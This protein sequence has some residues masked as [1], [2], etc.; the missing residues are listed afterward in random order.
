MNAI[1]EYLVS[2]M[3]AVYFVYGLA[4]FVLGV[5]LL[6]AARRDSSFR[7]ATVLAPLALFGLIHG[8]HEW[9][10]MFQLIAAGRTVYGSLDG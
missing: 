7:F 5:A 3:I 8:A 1:S 9:F 2:H 6:V 4:F 10:E